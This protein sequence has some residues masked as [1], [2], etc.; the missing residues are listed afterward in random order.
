MKHTQNILGTETKTLTPEA[1][2]WCESRGKQFVFQIYVVLGG[3]WNILLCDECINF[4]LRENEENIS[5]LFAQ[6]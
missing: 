4:C 5:N 3:S 1:P 2:P 6:Q